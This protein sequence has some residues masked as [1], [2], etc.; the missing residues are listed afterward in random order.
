MSQYGRSR[1][2]EREAPVSVS[3][4]CTCSVRSQWFSIKQLQ[5]THSITIQCLL[6]HKASVQTKKKIQT[7]E[8]EDSFWSGERKPCNRL[9]VAL[10]ESC[11]ISPNILHAKYPPNNLQQGWDCHESRLR[12]VHI[13]WLVLCQLTC[14]SGDYQADLPGTWLVFCNLSINSH[15]KL[16]KG[17]T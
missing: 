12:V 7:P 3:T 5:R 9:A 8:N 1:I 10:C 2:T 16:S 14:D 6:L 17:L 15:F 4:I 13:R 11:G